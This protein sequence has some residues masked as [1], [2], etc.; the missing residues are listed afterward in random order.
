MKPL[1][2]AF[3]LALGVCATV[4]AMRIQ[5]D[6][7]AFTSVTGMPHPVAF[8]HA[9]AIRPVP[10]P[11]NLDATLPALGRE[12]TLDEVTVWG[13]L[14]PKPRAQKSSLEHSV[15]AAPCNDGEYRRIDAIRGVRLMCPGGSLAAQVR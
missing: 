10:L 14:S 9:V 7:M 15:A 4:V 3:C 2:I 6:R 13:S 12:I 8:E 1:I 5:A 11:P